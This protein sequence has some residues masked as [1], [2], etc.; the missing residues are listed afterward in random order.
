MSSSQDLLKLILNYL[1]RKKLFSENPFITEEKI[2]LLIKDIFGHGDKR[3]PIHLNPSSGRSPDKKRLS[4]LIIHT[5][6]ASR[7]NPGRAGI[8]VAIYDKDY[9]LLEELCRFIGEATNNVAEYQAMILAAQKAILYKAE[10]VIFKT[11]S[12][13]L[14]KQLNGEYRVK[15]QNLLSLYNEL[16]GLLNRMPHWEIQYVPR[17]ENV[18]ADKLANKGIDSAH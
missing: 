8:G 18:L 9:N 4:K 7:G 5:D 15:N 17:E 3:E 11:D 1:D 13:L 6:G 10:E 2:D 12:E 14:V 16:M